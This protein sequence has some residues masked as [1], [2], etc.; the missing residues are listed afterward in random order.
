MTGGLGEVIEKL[1][2]SVN[3]LYSLCNDK[4]NAIN[5]PDKWSKEKL[6]ELLKNDVELCKQRAALK[7]QIDRM[8]LG[9]NAAQEIKSYGP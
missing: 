7:N 1:V 9:A 8:V 2:T 5:N 3:K 4:V 6:L